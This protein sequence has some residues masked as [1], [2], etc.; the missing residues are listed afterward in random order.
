MLTSSKI[1]LFVVLAAPLILPS[2]AQ[3][4]TATP[5]A[6]AEAANAAYQ[7]KDWATAARLYEQLLQANPKTPRLYYRLGTSLEELG[8][9]DKALDVLQKGLAEGLP[10]VYAEY[11]I[12][13]IYAGK[14][15]AE[16]SFEHLKKAI[17]NGYNRPDLMT[18]DEHLA[19]LRDDP[20]FAELLEAAKHNLKPCADTPENRQFDFWL[21]EWD[22]Q[23]TQ[24]GMPAGHSKIELILG[25]CVIQENWQSNGNPYSGK[26]YNVYNSALKRWEQYWVDS[27]GGNIFFHG[28]LRGGVMD[29]RTDDIP[30]PDGKLL[31]RHLQFFNLG[32]DKVRQFSQGSTD[33][34][35]TWHVEYDLTYIRHK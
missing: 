14:N 9:M 29:Y 23:T 13:T 16:K 11:A 28:G 34:G 31:R 33:G 21:G 22:V 18:S 19:S 12:A 27:V 6:T 25:D 35:K 10:Q 24:A 5:G 3:P 32:P 20:R 2:A 15:D 30:Q 8:Q 17:A 26:S 7:S 1:A 4:Q